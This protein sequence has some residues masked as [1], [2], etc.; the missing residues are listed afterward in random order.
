MPV[1]GNGIL[2][3]V[4]EGTTMPNAQVIALAGPTLALDNSPQH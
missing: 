4:P 1:Q 2:E 3:T